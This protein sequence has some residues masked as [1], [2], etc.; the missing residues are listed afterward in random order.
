MKTIAA[1]C[2]MLLATTA[3]AADPIERQVTVQGEAKV[4]VP[5]DFVVLS[6]EV[7]AEGSAVDRLKQDVDAKAARLL[8]AAASVKIAAADVKS[9][10]IRVSRE[11]QTD[12]NDNDVFKGYSVSRDMEIK[13]RR[14]ADYE[15]LAQA[16]VDAGVEQV[17]KI[18][19]GVDDESKLRNPA[20]AAAARDARSK[21]LAVSEALGIR[22]GL[23]IEVGEKRLWYDKVL[24]QLAPAGDYGEIV[25]T[26]SRLRSYGV[27]LFTPRDVEVEAEIWV[28]FAI[29]AAVTAP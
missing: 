16:L 19:V 17:S 23:P 8:E 14:V 15:L 6:L 25:V 21:A 22:I 12:R 27:L 10:G 11:Y 13:L 24:V 29:E 18:E 4:M 2:L 26:G 20:L 7:V 3:F 9:S 28:R 5:P 1:G